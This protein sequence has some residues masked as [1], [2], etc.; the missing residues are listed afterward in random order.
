MK[1][2][3]EKPIQLKWVFL[4]L[5]S[6]I[7]LLTVIIIADCLYDWRDF[8]YEALKVQ[9]NS[10]L[11]TSKAQYDKQLQTSDYL[12]KVLAGLNQNFPPE[13]VLQINKILEISGFPQYQRILLDSTKVK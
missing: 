11:Q 2:N 10:Q 8:R 5:T 7:L 9:Y 12:A 4:V 6:I 13:A 3:F 1:I